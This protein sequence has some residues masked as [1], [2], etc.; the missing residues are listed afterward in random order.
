MA[1]LRSP[2]QT[3]LQTRAQRS[4][5]APQLF[6]LALPSAWPPSPRP[7]PGPGP[8]PA[9]SPRRPCAP[10]AAHAP[11]LASS[12]QHS[13]AAPEGDP[14]G[15]PCL[16]SAFP[17]L[18]QV[19]CLTWRPQPPTLGR[20]SAALPSATDRLRSPAGSPRSWFPFMARVSK[21]V[22]YLKR[23]AIRQHEKE[24]IFRQTAAAHQP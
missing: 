23:C 2:Q 10:L 16:F 13:A 6:R 12:A 19:V 20:P 14:A 7:L 8:V 21:E 9:S 1:P 18:L 3:H 5:P 15:L 24:Q 22:N 4:C 11:S 17:P